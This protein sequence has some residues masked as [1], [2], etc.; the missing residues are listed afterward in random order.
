ME[1]PLSPLSEWSNPAG[2]W[3][4]LR[5]YAILDT[6]KFDE[7]LIKNERASLETP[8][9]YYKTMGNVLDT[10]GHLTPYEVVRSRQNWN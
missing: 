6:C 1:T 2:I 3:T 7:D 5:F 4:H 10:Q 8:F 9:P